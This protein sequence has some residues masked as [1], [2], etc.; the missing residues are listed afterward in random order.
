MHHQALTSRMH[1]RSMYKRESPAFLYVF[2]AIGDGLRELWHVCCDSF[3]NIHF[4]WMKQPGFDTKN[5]TGCC[6]C[7]D[8]ADS[9]AHTRELNWLKKIPRGE[10]DENWKNTYLLERCCARLYV[11]DELIMNFYVNEPLESIDIYHWRSQSGAGCRWYL[12]FY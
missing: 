11:V 7:W 1:S 4:Q 5:Q 12:I 10:S 9:I 8:E 6:C 3:S 2:V